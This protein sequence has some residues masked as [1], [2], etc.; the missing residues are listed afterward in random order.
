MAW[1]PYESAS[2]RNKAEYVFRRDGKRMVSDEGYCVR[3][4]KPADVL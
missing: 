2:F 1:Q 4:A 3:G